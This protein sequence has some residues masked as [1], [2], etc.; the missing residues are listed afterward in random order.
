MDSKIYQVTTPVLIMSDQTKH[1]IKS[2]DIKLEREPTPDGLYSFRFYGMDFGVPI[3][4]TP[5]LCSTDITDLK[6]EKNKVL[7]PVRVEYTVW[8]VWLTFFVLSIVTLFLY[9]SFIM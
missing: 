5:Y 3:I 1:Q 8:P 7:E 2:L 6:K 9:Y 4:T